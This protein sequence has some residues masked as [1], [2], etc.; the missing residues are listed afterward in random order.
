MREKICI[1][2]DWLFHK[3]DV[4][5][6]M[7]SNRGIAVLISRTEREHFSPASRHYTPTTDKSNNNILYTGETWKSVDL[8]HDFIIEGIPA[9][10]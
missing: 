3:G 7:P 10:S 6:S 9:S 2:K 8:P 1:N 5:T 4:K